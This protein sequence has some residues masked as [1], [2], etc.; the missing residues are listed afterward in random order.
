MDAFL[1]QGSYQALVMFLCIDSF[2]LWAL[3]ALQNISKVETVSFFEQNDP[4]W[5][6]SL[7]YAF[8]SLEQKRQFSLCYLRHQPVHDS[9]ECWVFSLPKIK[10]CF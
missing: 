10:G 4:Q 1:G 3:F 6:Q 5:L 9:Q 8:T 7:S 2:N